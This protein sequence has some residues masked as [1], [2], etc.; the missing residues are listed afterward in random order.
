MQKPQQQ[1]LALMRVW[2]TKAQAPVP[3][4]KAEQPQ[5][6][7]NERAHPSQPPE[8]IQYEW[9][10][11][12]S[13]LQIHHNKNLNCCLLY[14]SEHLN[15]C[16]LD[17]LRHLSLKRNPILVKTI[18]VFPQKITCT[19]ARYFVRKFLA[20]FSSVDKSPAIY[21]VFFSVP[22]SWPQQFLSDTRVLHCI[23]SFCCYLILQ[24]SFII[25]PFP[26]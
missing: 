4:W 20:I 6:G 3:V 25:L 16:V 2:K 24:A 1:T 23:L 12:K 8:N 19:L 5:Q 9:L 7:V 14:P 17:L 22:L 18:C 21:H 10:R 11:V 13:L 15:S 26:L